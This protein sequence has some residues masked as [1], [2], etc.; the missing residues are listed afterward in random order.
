MSD[1]VIAIVKHD[2]EIDDLISLPKFID[3]EKINS[4]VKTK[5]E[6][7]KWASEKIDSEFLYQYWN[8]S[9]SWYTENEWSENDLAV[10]NGPDNFTISLDHAHTATIENHFS[11][12]QFKE[13]EEINVYFRSVAFWLCGTLG[14]AQTI[15]TSSQSLYHLDESEESSWENIVQVFREKNCEFEILKTQGNNA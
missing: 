7:W 12:F 4:P 5:N 13:V 14:I 11:W 3:R 8:R 9:P 10:I 6:E 1:T 2:L 15:F